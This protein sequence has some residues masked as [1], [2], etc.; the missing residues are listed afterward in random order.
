MI[1]LEIKDNDGKVLSVGDT[2]RYYSIGTESQIHRG[3]NIPNGYY[4]EY[5]GIEC[6]LIEEVFEMPTFDLG[7]YAQLPWCRYYDE[8]W[9]RGAAQL[10][11][12][13]TI[14]PICDMLGIEAEPFTFNELAEKCNGFWIVSKAEEVA[15]K[16]SLLQRLFRSGK[17]IM[18][19]W[20]CTVWW[21]E[22]RFLYVTPD[23]MG[24]LLTDAELEAFLETELEKVKE[25]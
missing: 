3:D 1:Q 11:N 25:A 19:D 17:K 10:E 4:E 6:K 20:N 12:T 5:L 15:P 14:E 7:G 18:L 24:E 9:L 23:A 2:V 16:P 8:D 21:S 22:D 13:A